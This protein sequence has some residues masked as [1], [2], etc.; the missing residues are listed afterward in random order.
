V[1]S[2]EFALFDLPVPSTPET[3]DVPR[4]GRNRETFRR[5]VE[6]RVRVDRSAELRAAAWQALD[7]GVYVDL[8]SH[9]VGPGSADTELREEIENT[10]DTALS[11][12]IEPLA[13]L[14]D[15]LADGVVRVDEAS[16]EIVLIDDRH[17]RASWTTTLRL[18]DA[19][20]FHERAI[21]ACPP[22]DTRGGP[23]PPGH[24]PP[25]GSA[26]PTRTSRSAKCPASRGPRAL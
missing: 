2:N 13:G 21:A 24:S 10:D 19:R 12:N 11:W 5:I 7:D 8:D 3:T 1:D 9:E 26:S 22:G 18:N 17:Y 25:R 20:A 4:P 23:R 15:L 16:S 14:W 6:V